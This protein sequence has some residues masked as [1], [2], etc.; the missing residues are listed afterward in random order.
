MKGVEGRGVES[1][2]KTSSLV[3]KYNHTFWP[4]LLF[5]SKYLGIYIGSFLGNFWLALKWCSTLKIFPQNV[6]LWAIC[7]TLKV[8]MFL[9]VAKDRY[10]LNLKLYVRYFRFFRKITTFFKKFHIS[11]AKFSV[12]IES[13]NCFANFEVYS[14]TIKFS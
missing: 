3:N 7:P 14:E 10:I 12:S 13:S 4:V 11:V 6:S 2:Q 5:Y 1:K 9:T 8:F